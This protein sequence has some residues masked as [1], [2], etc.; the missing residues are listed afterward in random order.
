M[1]KGTLGNCTCEMTG[2]GHGKREAPNTA[3]WHQVKDLG[4]GICSLSANPLWVRRKRHSV[5]LVAAQG[6]RSP[7]ASSPAD[8]EKL[9]CSLT[10]SKMPRGL[11]N[12]EVCP[13]REDGHKLRLYFSP[14]ACKNL[15][16]EERYSG[17]PFSPAL[18]MNCLCPH[19]T[20]LPETLSAQTFRD[21]GFPCL[22]EKE[23]EFANCRRKRPC[24]LCP[25]LVLGCSRQ[26]WACRWGS[27]VG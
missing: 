1:P 3:G 15:G 9:P 24:W 5:Q 16:K 4:P 19:L 14:S 13:D 22:M 7:L 12:L 8:R 21:L 6:G 23:E 26:Q 20:S 10:L 2:K 18:I 25:Q 11:H 27:A 17:V